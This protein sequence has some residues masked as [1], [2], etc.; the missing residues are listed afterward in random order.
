[1]FNFA[2][3]IM[4]LVIGAFNLFGNLHDYVDPGTL[5][6]AVLTQMHTGDAKFPVVTYTP[7]EL[8]AIVGAVLLTLQ[9]ANYGLMLW[10]S[11]QRMK[12]RKFSFWV[13]LVGAGIS[14]VLVFSTLAILLFSDPEVR[15]AL[16]TF[17]NG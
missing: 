1:M 8:T 5:A 6:N 4:L 9:G 13:P 11:I 15:A 2:L 14:S 3:T 12:A 16:L 7:T 10:W 17:A